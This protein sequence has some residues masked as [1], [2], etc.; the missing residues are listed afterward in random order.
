MTD[1]F[2]PWFWL[3]NPH[4]QTVV[5]VYCKGKAFPYRTVRRRVRLPDG[6]QLV[7]HDTTPPD[8]KPG[9][10]VAILVHGLGGSHRSG[11]IVRL[12]RL[13]L[14]PGV[15]VV[16]LDLRGTG[17][18][19]QLARG[20][21]NAGCSADVRAAL[22]V[23]HRLAPTSPL[24]LAG[25]SLGANVS[26]KLAGEAS[27][28][29]VAGLAKVGTIAPPVDLAECIRRLEQPRNRFYEVHFLRDLVREARLRARF[30]S[31]PSPPF[32]RR[33][34]LRQF[35]DLYTA[36]RG[37][38]RDAADYY[39]RS[40]SAQFVPRVQ[41]PTLILTARDDPFVSWEP[42]AGLQCPANVEVRITDHGGHVGY[43][44]RDGTGG[45]CWGEWQVA[46]WLLED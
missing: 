42:I 26:L 13:L 17:A 2:R 32:P 36:P 15:R 10:P 33:M 27:D 1:V 8:W 12:A 5:G 29:P 31:E 38:F 21:Y 28:R 16:R 30:F 41:L 25:V 40:S 6:D 35:D 3:R 22:E 37:G 20:S 7:L 23:V 45:I 9:D 39:A 24:W 43:V 4:V 44:G 34:S 19:F 46:R 18:G 14:R 11:G